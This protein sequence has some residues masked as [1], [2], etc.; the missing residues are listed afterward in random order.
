MTIGS[1]LLAVE[2][3]YDLICYR[4]AGKDARQIPRVGMGDFLYEDTQ[5]MSGFSAMLRD[6]LKS[7]LER[8]G[9]FKVISRERL[10]DVL[11][12]DSIKMIGNAVLPV[13]NFLR[14]SSLPSPIKTEDGFMPKS[15]KKMCGTSKDI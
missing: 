12:Q 3:D 9:K 6:E 7:A 2:S 11:E 13:Y 8:S 4:L 14:T 10:K 1:S 5:F 15:S